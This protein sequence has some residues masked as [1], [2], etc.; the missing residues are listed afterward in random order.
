[1]EIS[2]LQKERLKYE[3]KLPGMLQLKELKKNIV[4]SQRG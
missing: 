3:P 2:P 4:P 1:M